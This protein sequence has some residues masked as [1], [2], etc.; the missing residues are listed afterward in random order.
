MSVGKMFDLSIV[1]RIKTRL[2]D[3]KNNKTYKTEL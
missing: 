2:N 3:D 1:G